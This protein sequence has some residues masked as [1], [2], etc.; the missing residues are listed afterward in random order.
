MFNFA[1][2]FKWGEGRHKW[3]RCRCGGAPTCNVTPLVLLGNIGKNEA[4]PGHSSTLRHLAPHFKNSTVIIGD[5]NT[6]TL[7]LE[8]PIWTL[9]ARRSTR[10]SAEDV[11]EIRYIIHIS[12]NNI[13]DRESMKYCL[14]CLKRKCDSIQLTHAKLHL[15][16]LLPT[17]S[18]YFNVRVSELN[19]RILELSYK[20]KYI[21]H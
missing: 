11:P 12:I 21:Y 13:N 5:S 20:Q 6:K 7:N 9:A 16:L 4:P 3:G 18:T 8:W 14:F 10:Y 17:K 2:D 19:S 15:S 1:F